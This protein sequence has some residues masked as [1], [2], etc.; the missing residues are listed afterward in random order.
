MWLCNNSKQLKIGIHRIVAHLVYGMDLYDSNIHVNHLNEKRS[1]N[2]ACNLRPGN[3]I[4]NI[5]WSIKSKN[6]FTRVTETNGKYHYLIY[7][8]GFN[9]EEEA[10]NWKLWAFNK[11]DI[12]YLKEGFKEPINRDKEWVSL[13]IIGEPDY[14]INKK[15]NI[16]NIS[17]Y[18][19][20]NHTEDN[21]MGLWKKKFK[22]GNIYYMF[23]ASRKTFLLHNVLAKCFI[24]NPDPEKYINCVS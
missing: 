16:L 3:A 2:R 4:N 11:L 7:K 8:G 17:K 23:S 20:N 9:N 15:G 18:D 22:S 10:N 24:H 19:I 14:V 5:N 21:Y 12:E 6:E 1:D 13:D